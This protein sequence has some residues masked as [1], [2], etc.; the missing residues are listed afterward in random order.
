MEI[1]NSHF[2]PETLMQ[3]LKF[4]ARLLRKSPGFAMVAVLTLALGIGPTT[5]VFSVVDTVLLSPLPYVH[6]E[7]LAIVS[8][9]VPNIGE[10]PKTGDEGYLGVAAGEYLDYRD[11]NR[12]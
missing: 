3:D 8:E 1:E 2:S 11:R 4:G 10:I 7:Q 6:P 9:T 5:A 12:S